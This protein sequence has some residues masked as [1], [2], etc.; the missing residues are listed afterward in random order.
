VSE[1]RHKIF[2]PKLLDILSNIPEYKTVKKYER[3]E[4]DFIEAFINLMS[5]E[6]YLNPPSDTV[7]DLMLSQKLQELETKIKYKYNKK[8]KEKTNEKIY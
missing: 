1:N 4:K 2:E 8:Y 6:M 3:M 7:R 5:D